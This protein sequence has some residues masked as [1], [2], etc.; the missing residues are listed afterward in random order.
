MIFLV[1][2]IVNP[3]KFSLGNFTTKNVQA[4]QVFPKIIYEHIKLT[5]YSIMN[6]RLAAQVLSS[7]VSNVLSNYA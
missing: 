1:G 4:S 2:N 7:T 5:S 3:F 6:V